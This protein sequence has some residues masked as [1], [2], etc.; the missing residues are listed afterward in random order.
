M[1]SENSKTLMKETENNTDGKINHALVSLSLS[2]FFFFRAASAAYGGS[3]A[4]GQ[5]G[6]TTA[7]LHH[8]HSN[9]GSKQCLQP[10]AQLTVMLDPEPTEQG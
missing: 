8:G 2:L 1:N 6:A 10:T 9:V 5:I 7:S 4:K 3:Q